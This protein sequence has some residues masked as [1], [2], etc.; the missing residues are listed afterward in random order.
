MCALCQLPATHDIEVRYAVNILSNPRMVLNYIDP[1]SGYVLGSNF[2]ALL[3][4][5][6]GGFFASLFFL[7]NRIFPFF[8]KKRIIII[9]AVAAVI[10]G[11]IFFMSGQT[12]SKKNKVVI[13][14]FDGMDPNILEKGFENGRFPNLKKLKETGFYSHL[15]TTVP[16]QSPVAWASFITGNDPSKHGIYDFIE[17]DSSSYSLNVV[18]SQEG[19]RQDSIKSTPFWDTTTKNKIPSTVLF[20]PDTFEPPKTFTGEMIAGM[21]VPDLLGT[22][23]TFTLF[24]TKKYPTDDFTWRGKVIPVAKESTIST[25]IEGPKYS[26]IDG[27]KVSTIPLE[28]KLV[29]KDKAEVTVQKQTFTLTKGEFSDW[30]RLEFSIDFFTKVRGI[31]KFYLKNSDSNFELYMSPIN[32]DPEAPLKSI[33]T[34]KNFSVKLS[35]DLGMYSTLGLPHDT[36]A[37]EEDVFDEKAFLKQADSILSERKKIY[38][39]K[40]NTYNSGILFAYFGMPDTISHMFWRFISDPASPYYD[41]INQYYDKMDEIV[42]ETLKKIDRD[43]TL[44]ILSDHGFYSFDYE[45]NVNTFL[46]QNGYLVLKDGETESGPL[47]DQVDWSKTKAYAAG[48]NSIFFNIVGRESQG[49][50]KREDINALQ[51]EIIA[52]FMETTNPINNEKIMKKVY[53]RQ[54]LGISQDDNNA[55]DLILG[56]YKGIRSSWDSAIG[57]TAPEVVRKRIYKWSG[58]HLFDPTEVPGV[59][60]SNKKI[61]IK[62]PKITNIMPMVLNIFKVK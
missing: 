10:T 9:L 29:D 13:L 52:K 53:S 55:P 32:F 38:Y 50:V 54:D 5:I 19:N 20:L 60:L 18:F 36:W 8:T 46:L 56:F 4:I 33:S 59:L 7:R 6:A 24:T 43:T 61:G 2:T 25:K 39:S 47:Y 31:V 51:Q 23:G 14:G 58:D 44:I 17:R 22:Q 37:L 26:S 49:I 35:K 57:A 11:I 27:T 12:I 34:P 1:G 62:N 45:M 15:A 21:G 28:I 3:S 30:K 16:P 48:Y 42:G 40:L 41:T